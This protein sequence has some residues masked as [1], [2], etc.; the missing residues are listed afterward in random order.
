MSTSA[1][2]SNVSTP[3]WISS[4]SAISHIGRGYLCAYA[5]AFFTG[6]VVSGLCF[7]VLAILSFLAIFK[8]NVLGLRERCEE[9]RRDEKRREFV[10]REE[11]RRE[12]NKTAYSQQRS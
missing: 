6:L 8:G 12:D 11:K 3:L 1:F 4:P 9:K 2:V 10:T 5:G 7:L